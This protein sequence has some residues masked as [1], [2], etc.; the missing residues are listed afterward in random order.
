MLIPG[1]GLTGLDREDLELNTLHVTGD[2]MMYAYRSFAALGYGRQGPRLE[3][4]IMDSVILL[5][6]PQSI[7]SLGLPSHVG[8]KAKTTTK[9]HPCVWGPTVTASIL[10]R[11]PMYFA[12][13]G[14][15]TYR[16]G[17]E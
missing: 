13:Q 1:V 2:I 17:P 16:S 4:P 5:Q 11:P 6:G 8:I 12:R 3:E 10:S 15:K 9:Q 7:S 14:S